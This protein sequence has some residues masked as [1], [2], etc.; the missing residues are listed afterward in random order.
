MIHE[1]QSL[2]QACSLSAGSLDTAFTTLVLR[3]FCVT[4]DDSPN[5]QIL[6]FNHNALLARNLTGCAEKYLD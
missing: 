6:D 2:T 1:L 3:D 4:L 5:L